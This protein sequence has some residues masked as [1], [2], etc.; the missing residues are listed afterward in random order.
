MGSATAKSPKKQRPVIKETCPSFRRGSLPQYDDVKR[1]R[2][3][4]VPHVGSFDYFLEK[5]LALGCAD[6][7]PFE[8]DL[9]NPAKSG[10]GSRTNS[11]S[12]P[13]EVQ[14]LKMWVSNVKVDRPVKA[15]FSNNGSQLTPRECRELG[16]VYSGPMMGEL[17]Y[18]INHRKIDENQSMTEI[19]GK[20]VR[21]RKKFGDMPIMVMSKACH[22]H[23]KKPSELVAMKEEVGYSIVF[24][25]V[26]QAIFFFSQELS[27][28]HDHA[29]PYPNPSHNYDHAL[30]HK[31][32]SNHSKMN[33]EDT[34][35]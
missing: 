17:C 18:Q 33:S 13:R 3:L 29:L 28:N 11:S 26:R 5:G 9:V 35:S 12:G 30:T 1:L 23:N 10:N 4:S 15:D 25:L 32:W 21:I 7:V 6:I 22:L 16:L 2:T 31:S 34:S 8:I 14:T 19:P 27:H 24:N 20:V